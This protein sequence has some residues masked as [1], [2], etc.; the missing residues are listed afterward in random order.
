[1][2][3]QPGPESHIAGNLALISKQHLDSRLILSPKHSGSVE[4]FCSTKAL[5]EP[6]PAPDRIFSQARY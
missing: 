2:S 1:M 3:A 6:K 4:D 5:E